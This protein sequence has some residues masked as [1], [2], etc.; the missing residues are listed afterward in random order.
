M[1]E[2]EIL[3]ARITKLETA[4]QQI[5]DMVVGEKVPNWQDTLSTTSSRVKIADICDL[6][7]SNVPSKE[8]R[9][10]VVRRKEV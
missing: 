10:R 2:H 6:V 1:S 4:L 8:H 7:L 9:M 3:R 5:K